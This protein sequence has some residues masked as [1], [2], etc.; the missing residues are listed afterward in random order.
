[1][2]EYIAEMPSYTYAMKAERLLKARGIRCEIKRREE[3]CGYNLHV[4][5][6]TSLEILRQNAVPYKLKQPEV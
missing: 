1:M 3:G 4:Y 6:K 2:I 5:N